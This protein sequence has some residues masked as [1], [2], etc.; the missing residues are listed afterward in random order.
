G[1]GTGA[2]AKLVRDQQ[3]AARELQALDKALLAELSK[4][5]STRD[6]A[7]EDGG[8]SQMTVLDTKLRQLNDRLTAEFPD[9]AAL[10]GPKP[11]SAT[12]AQ[13]LLAEDEALILLLAG[14]KESQVFAATRDGFVWQTV[15]IDAATLSQ[16]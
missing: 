9:Y 8:R 4:A 13:K 16:K 14:D 12:E 10:G 6:R 2:L 3:D 7:R 1:S 11:L 5:T 15:P